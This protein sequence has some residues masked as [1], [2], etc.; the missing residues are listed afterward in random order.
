MAFRKIITMPTNM[1]NIIIFIDL[2]NFSIENSLSEKNV[3][4]NIRKEI[5]KI[6]NKTT[7]AMT[8]L[9]IATN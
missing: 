7:L 8:S 4:I 1:I 5:P 2:G 3:P 6:I 9:I